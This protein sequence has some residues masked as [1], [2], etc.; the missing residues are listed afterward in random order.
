M[1]PTY[2]LFCLLF[3]VVVHGAIAWSLNRPQDAGVDVPS[4]K[5]RSLSFAPYREGFSPIEEKFPLPEHIDADLGL[6]ADKTHTIRTYSILGGMQPTPEFARKHGVE[7]IQGGWL[8]DGHASN[9]KEI[10]A[11]IEAV[12]ANPDVVKRVLVGNEVLLRKDMDVDTLIGYIRQ[13][14]QA[15]KQP[16]SYADVWSIYLKYPQ[17][18]QE[19]DFITV[20]ILPY[21]EDEPVAIEDAAG[22][23]EKIVQ[24]IQDKAHSMGLNKPILIGESGWPAAGRQRG[25]AVP[26]VV[27]ETRFIRSLIEVVNRHGL[28]Y[29][30][31]EAFNQPWKSHNEGV[32]G[33]NWGLLTID[34]EPVFPLTG[35]VYENPDWLLHFA[36]ATGLWL[37]LASIYFKKLQNLPWPR[38]LVFLTLAQIFGVCLVTLADFLWFTSYSIWQQA[39]T[40]LLVVANGLLS[41]LLLQRCYAILAHQAAL[42]ALA[43]RLRSAYLF[44]VVLALYKTYSL[45]FNGRYLSF[46]V[47]QFAIPAIG[48]CGLIIC[49]YLAQR[50]LQWHMLRFD[51]LC[52]GNSQTPRDRLLAYFL[53]FGMLAVVIGETHE[54]M[55]A[56]DFIQAHPGFSEGLPVAL[57]YTFYNQQLTA[58]LLCILVLSIP[59]WPLRS[60]KA[61]I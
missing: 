29:N 13:V 4:G 42:P 2:L 45:A 28:D 34:R 7:M 56:Y 35:P 41:G 52:G 49:L 16:V 36:W 50:R 51:S 46:P 43:N 10:A 59:F 37:L 6:I 31:V 53:N 9:K 60:D 27:N 26:S 32:V 5:L 18:M 33:A 55:A 11:L 20:H 48:I 47:E 15:V 12:N 40:V 3:I 44:F 58:W 38:L 30:I 61:K 21:W 1:R 17:L 57:G 25:Q 19:V 24:Q 14:K 54:F 22:H 39:Y 8:G 23:V